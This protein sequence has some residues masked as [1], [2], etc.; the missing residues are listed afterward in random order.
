MIKEW[1][2]AGF[3]IFVNVDKELTG[4]TCFYPLHQDCFCVFDLVSA[5]GIVQCVIPSSHALPQTI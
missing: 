1:R 5:H 4:K 2:V 3:A